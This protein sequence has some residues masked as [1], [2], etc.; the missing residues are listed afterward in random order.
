MS[1]SKLAFDILDSPEDMDLDAR[2]NLAKICGKG[3]FY[4]PYRKN[5]FT[6][7]DE[8]FGISDGPLWSEWYGS[9]CATVLFGDKFASLSHRN[10]HHEFG[11]VTKR[12]ME[13]S[14]K[15]MIKKGE[16]K[17][18]GFA[19]GGDPKH[20]REIVESFKE[21]EIEILNGGK[22]VSDNWRKIA[23][24]PS[25]KEIV[26]CEQDTQESEK[27]YKILTFISRQT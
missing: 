16:N 9:C 21:F 25:R 3:I 23:I 27:K 12:E 19:I 17:I 14:T 15:A 1:L 4:N 13:F 26:L 10:L 5:I 8:G 11:Y 18:S 24:I 2:Y 6:S 7:K 22:Y 20:I